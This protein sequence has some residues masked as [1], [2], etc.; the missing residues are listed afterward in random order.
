[1]VHALYSQDQ[2]QVIKWFDKFDKSAIKEVI[3][4]HLIKHPKDTV[5]HTKEHKGIKKFYGMEII[6][7]YKNNSNNKPSKVII[8]GN[9]EYLKTLS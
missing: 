5:E 8:R 3:K 9:K 6:N 2:D 1:M 7:F 4:E